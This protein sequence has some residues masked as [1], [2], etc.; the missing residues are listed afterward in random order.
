MAFANKYDRILHLIPSFMTSLIIAHHHQS[1]ED[2]SPRVHYLARNPVLVV[3]SDN[4]L[5]SS[6]RRGVYLDNRI[7]NSNLQVVFSDNP[8][9]SNPP[10]AYS[11]NLLSSRRRPEGSLGNQLS[12]S[13]NSSQ[14]ADCSANHLQGGAS[15]VSRRGNSS[16]NQLEVC[17]VNRPNHSSSQQDHSLVVPLTPR[18]NNSKAAHSER[19]HQLPNL[20]NRTLGYLGKHCSLK[21]HFL[22]Q[23]L[24][25]IHRYSVM[26]SSTH[27]NS[28]HNPGEGFICYHVE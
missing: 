21:P 2:P 11:D 14:V 1:L 28:N 3:C 15:L 27:S 6:S 9:S 13:S 10:E 25:G 17:L 24:E 19:L 8:P 12:S 7:N 22:L 4:L 26:L 20:N 23:A 16:S 18:N 5:S